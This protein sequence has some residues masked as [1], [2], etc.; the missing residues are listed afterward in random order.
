MS[1]CHE[2]GGRQWNWSSL[3]H[4]V[5]SSYLYYV[6]RRLRNREAPELSGHVRRAHVAVTSDANLE[7]YDTRQQLGLLYMRQAGLTSKGD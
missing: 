7:R 6:T 4:K 1:S 5:R 2:R 3:Y